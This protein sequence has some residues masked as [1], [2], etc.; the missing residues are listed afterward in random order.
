MV[1]LLGKAILVFRIEG[2]ESVYGAWEELENAREV[3]VS[4]NGRQ[5]N[6]LVIHSSSSSPLLV[7]YI[8]STVSGI[9]T[10][11]N[12]FNSQN[13]GVATTIVSIL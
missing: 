9:F 8:P 5:Q 2:K 13:S 3:K 7:C 10:C 6:P 1:G 11:N 4:I 12:S